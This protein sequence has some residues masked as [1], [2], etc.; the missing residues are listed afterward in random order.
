M[1]TN[2]DITIKAFRK[3]KVLSLS[4]LMSLLK[5]SVATA[6][7]RL[8]AWRAYT[9]YNLNGR[10]YTLPDVPQFDENGLWKF[11]SKMF[12]RFGNLKATVVS[13]VE[14][15]RAGLNAFEMSTL[16][17][18]PA[19]TFLSHFKEDVAL[20]R[21]KIHGLYV[22][23]SH[24]LAT[25]HKQKSE[26]DKQYSKQAKEDLPTDAESVAILVELIK[27]PHDSLPQLVGRAKR[28]GLCV[29]IVKVR[30]L[31]VHHGILKKSAL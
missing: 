15:S 22:Y 14:H 13:L 7:R 26:R 18:L 20:R 2:E 30:N 25:Y 1:K 11:D 3:R 19:H 5:C 12:S 17:N 21:E 4:N 31:L 24:E 9:S 28:K 27:H 23:F 29:P 10:Y 16:L 6:R 8:A